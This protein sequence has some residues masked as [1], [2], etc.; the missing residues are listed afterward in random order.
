MLLLQSCS[1]QDSM[2]ATH[3]QQ[4][5]MGMSRPDLEA[6]LGVPD[7]RDTFEDTDILTWYSTS[8]SA[9]GLSVGLPVVGDLSLSGGGSCH[10]VVRLE[11]G[12]VTEVRYT[13]ENGAPLAPQS[14]CA[15]IVRSCVAYPEPR[16]GVV[17]PPGP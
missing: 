13:G 5:I 7:Q 17:P 12:V 4:V 14:Y 6:C 16:R 8:S 2:T 15:P 10:A 3:G 9:R 1:V 11:R